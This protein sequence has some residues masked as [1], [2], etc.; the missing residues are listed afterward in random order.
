[1]S[2][3]PLTPFGR[4]VREIRQRSDAELVDFDYVDVWAT[5][6][7]FY[8]PFAG[9]FDHSG[10]VSWADHFG[11]REFNYRVGG[12]KTTRRRVANFLSRGETQRWFAARG[13]GD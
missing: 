1:M 5:V 13:D 12:P 8:R 6:Q 3:D 2:G 11:L 10:S 4:L 7:W 9:I